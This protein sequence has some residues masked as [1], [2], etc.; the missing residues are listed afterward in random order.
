MIWFAFSMED[1]VEKYGAYVGIAA[2]FGLA[3][4]SLLYFSQ[5]RELKR[6]REWAGRAPERAQEL[7]Q[8]VVA[9]AAASVAA[10]RPAQAGQ[11]AAGQ[12][13]G[14]G[15]LAPPRKL[16]EMPAQTAAGAATATAVGVAE[17]TGT[18]GTGPVPALGPGGTVPAGRVNGSPETGD[19]VPAGA[20][21]EDGASG[22]TR[23]F[24]AAE[25]AAA[26]GAAAPS[27]CR[28]RLPHRPRP[29]L[30]RAPPPVPRPTPRPAPR[31]RRA[32]GPARDARAARRRRPQADAA[33]PDAGR[34]DPA[35][36]RR[37]WAPPVGTRAAPRPRPPRWRPLGRHDRPARRPRRADPRRRRLHRLAAARRRRRAGPAEPGRRAAGRDRRAQLE[38][39][40]TRAAS[41]GGS[42]STPPKG[43]TNV[44]VL[45]G[46]TFTGLA[47]RLADEV[48][49]DGYQRGVTETNTRDQTIEQSVVYY[50]DGYR[51]SARAIARL[52][53]IDQ[54][55]ALD[56][57]TA[58]VA[59]GANVV[60]LAGAD[61]AP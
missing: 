22:E 52:L 31:P 29:R 23:P 50:A 54:A 35:Q 12:A 8:R 37:R 25:A 10:R 26:T 27:S 28:P 14:T 45:N 13:T 9:Q 7:E 33:G 20:P 44:A 39:A 58:A 15:T 30:R 2:F 4:L 3:V 40:G 59:P 49:G 51:N 24:D 43:E 21:S 38:P 18:N 61:Q 16:A 46:T 42:A 60:V 5:A 1:Q 32:R 6:L 34:R 56:S 55:E 47:G 11:A 48:A 19:E 36:L 17:H 41:G 53:S 57:E